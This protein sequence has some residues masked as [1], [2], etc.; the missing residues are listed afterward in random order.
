MF[1]LMPVLKTS[2]LLKIKTMVSISN[3]LPYK[4]T[5]EDNFIFSNLLKRNPSKSMKKKAEN[6][7]WV[8]STTILPKLKR[9]QT[10]KPKKKNMMMPASNSLKE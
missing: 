10:T 2:Q 9:S 4:L 5:I 7:L 6:L 1:T 8:V 3:F